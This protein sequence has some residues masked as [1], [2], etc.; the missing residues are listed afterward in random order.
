MKAF[1]LSNSEINFDI[2]QSKCSNLGNQ[3]WET[4]FY[5]FYDD[6]APSFSEYKDFLKNFFQQKM[7]QTCD[8]IFQGY[9][10][11]VLGCFLHS[12]E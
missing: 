4:S 9:M 10:K 3:F 2:N 8:M 6:S 5:R 12:F 1:W 7:S 11:D